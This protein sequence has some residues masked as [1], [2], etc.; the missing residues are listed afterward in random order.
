MQRPSTRFG[1]GEL[2][3]CDAYF[4][5]D[6]PDLLYRL[7]CGCS[8]GRP[9]ERC[10]HSATTTCAVL[11]AQG[12]SCNGLTR[13]RRGVSASERSAPEGAGLVGLHD[14]ASSTNQRSVPEG[15]S[16][17]AALQNE[18]EARYSTSGISF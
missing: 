11:H 3:L 4:L 2:S 12:M 18:A 15:P 10:V 14:S 6:W 1:S 7:G 13:S 16:G 9:P 8:M 17:S 5:R